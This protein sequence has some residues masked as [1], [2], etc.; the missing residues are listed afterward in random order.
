MS[1]PLEK[2]GLIDAAKAHCQEGF[3]FDQFCERRR[4]Q[5]LK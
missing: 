3:S 1:I 4:S 5:L 2:Q